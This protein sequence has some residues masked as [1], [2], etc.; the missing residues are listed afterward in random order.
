MLQNQIPVYS[1]AGESEHWD[2]I[3]GYMY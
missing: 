3:E 1:R 2:K